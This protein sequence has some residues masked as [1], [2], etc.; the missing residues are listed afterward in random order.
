MSISREHTFYSL[1]EKYI[2]ILELDESVLTIVIRGTQCNNGKPYNKTLIAGTTCNIG[3]LPHYMM[4]MDNAFS[5]DENLQCF[6]EGIE[7]GLYSIS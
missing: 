1:Y 6:I 3:L 2:G 4:R 7:D 5:I